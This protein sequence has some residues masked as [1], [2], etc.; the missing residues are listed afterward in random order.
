M[1]GLPGDVPG[2]RGAGGGGR[3]GGPSQGGGSRGGPR[4]E[5]YKDLRRIFEAKKIMIFTDKW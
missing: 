1:P 2:G 4:H 5:N 3:G